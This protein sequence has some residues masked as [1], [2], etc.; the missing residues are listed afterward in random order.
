MGFN[1]IDFNP[2]FKV[3]RCAWSCISLFPCLLSNKS[4]EVSNLEISSRPFFATFTFWV[5]FFF[6]L[7]SIFLCLCYALI[8]SLTD[9]LNHSL[10]H[11]FTLPFHSLFTH[12]CMHIYRCNYIVCLHLH[13]TLSHSSHFSWY[14]QMSH[15]NTYS[16]IYI[17]CIRYAYV[18]VLI[19]E[20]LKNVHAYVAEKG[21]D[22]DIILFFI[23][24]GRSYVCTWV[25]ALHDWAT[26]CK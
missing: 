22:T 1:L 7:F 10:T 18:K 13:A 6:L 8:D 5:S 23:D 3:M 26:R 16:Y 2:N 11:P 20:L 4:W 12:S 15:E 17:C 14:C 9:W 24:P 21:L 25:F 19:I